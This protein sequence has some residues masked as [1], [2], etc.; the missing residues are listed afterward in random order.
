MNLVIELNT[1]A[2]V[3]A[4]SGAP[5]LFRYPVDSL[6]AR[7]RENRALTVRFCRNGSLEDIHAGADL[8][9]TV[10]RTANYAAST[11]LAEAIT[12]TKYGSGSNAVYSS[13]I[14]LFTST[15]ETAFGAVNGVEPALIETILE[16]SWTYDGLRYTS[17]AI[18]L[19]LANCVFRDQDAIPET[20]S[21]PPVPITIGSV[22]ASE[23]GGDASVSNRGTAS[24][25]ILDFVVPRGPIGPTG[26]ANLL[27]IGQVQRGDD[28]S[29]SIRGDS[30]EQ[31]LDFVLPKGDKGDQ[32]EAAAISIGSV[33]AGEPDTE[34]SVVNSGTSGN[35]VLDFVIPGG[36]NGTDG[37]NGSNGKTIWSGTG[38][39]NFVEGAQALDFYL[40]TTAHALYGPLALDGDQQ[41]WGDPTSLV[42]P[43]GATGAPT[44]IDISVTQD[45]TLDAP[46]GTV[47][48]G[49]RVI[50]RI[51]QDSYGH[52]VTLGS[53][54]VVP[55]GMTTPVLGTLANNVDILGL[56]YSAPS[57]RWLVASHLPGC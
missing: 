7:R 22:T 11:P 23:P 10:K 55:S 14:N 53:S 1:Q 31:V 56:F 26:P 35:A 39:P 4:V 19:K 12:F 44:I 18:P 21:P 24:A 29:V 5:D 43:A 2:F 54:L 8:R 17:R 46:S 49:K 15:I 45:T 9:L 50:Y 34:P 32:G 16:V 47:F 38:S 36:R 6:D 40:D 33:T 52:N 41:F 28:A 48:D 42:G 30:P 25:A 3:T 37:T 20:T 27:S 57:S 51:T 13:E